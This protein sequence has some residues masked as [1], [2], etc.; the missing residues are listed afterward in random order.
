MVARL[1]QPNAVHHTKTGDHKGRPY[2]Q[3]GK[4]WLKVSFLVVKGKRLPSIAELGEVDPGARNALIRDFNAEENAAIG[5]GHDARLVNHGPQFGL[6]KRD[7]RAP[8]ILAP[9]GEHIH[10]RW[11]DRSDELGVRD[12]E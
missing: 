3:S 6:P 2:E 11:E 7:E 4:L 10:E 1:R 8:R 12:V 9:D 5:I